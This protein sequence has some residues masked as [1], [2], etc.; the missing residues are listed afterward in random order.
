MWF[1][2]RSSFYILIFSALLV[3]ALPAAHAQTQASCSFKP[4]L[5]NPSGKN[6]VPHVINVNERHVPNNAAISGAN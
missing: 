6:L 2:V 1:W 3:L 5:L 4:V